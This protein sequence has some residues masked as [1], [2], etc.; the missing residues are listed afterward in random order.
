MVVLLFAYR[1][2][3]THVVGGDITYRH[4][5]NDSFEITLILYI[6]CING[7]P[8]AIAQDANAMIGVF[9]TTGNLLKTLL[10]NRSLPI[11]IN[12]VN[13]NCVQPPSN[14]C[15][16]KYTYTYYTSLPQ[17][18]G[19]IILAFQRCCRN[20]SITNIINPNATGA[21]YWTRI[22]DTAQTNGYNS[23][24][25]FY[26]LPPNFLCNNSAFVFNHA[27]TDP[28]GDSLSYELYTPYMGADQSNPLPR[29]PATPP[30]YGVVWASPFDVNN[31]MKGLPEL[32]ID[33]I[34][35]VITMIPKIVGQF[36]VGIGVKEFRKGLLIGFTRRDF[37]FNVL[38]CQ[39]NI[40]SSFTKD[41]K[42]CNDTVAFINNSV[43]A[44]SYLWDFGDSTSSIDTSTLKEPTYVYPKLGIYFIKLL[45]K[46]GNCSDSATAQ[47]IISRDTIPFAGKDTIICIGASVLLGTNDTNMFNYRWQPA[48]F[49]NDSSIS[50]PLA[51]PQYS[52]KYYVTRTNDICI[53]TDTV[54]IT[55]KN[56]QAHFSG[57]T[58]VNCRE[59]HIVIDSVTTFQEM[60]WYLNDESATLDQIKAKLLEKGKTYLVK[61]LVSD[62]QC[63][64]SLEK[65]LSAFSTDTISFIPNVFTP[66]NDK[67]NDCY[68]IEYIQLEKECANLLI[69][70]RWGALMYNSDEDGTC[71]DGNWKGTQATEGVYFY[72]LKH[73]GK[74]YHGTIT[75]I[76]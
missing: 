14:A 24:P 52:I 15:V 45:V 33:S 62:G 29:P 48:L 25:V 21:T 16:D 40:V 50:R 44:D 69:Y 65:L 68:R 23:S 28:D 64:D 61:L 42:V 37:Q 32:K 70:N 53:N 76:R 56:L 43:G 34:S 3:A 51:T 12:S 63:F 13:Y 55:V 59:A 57:N 11:R 54:S 5:V 19:G 27:A 9:D 4:I 18:P 73:M 36:V 8:Q 75:L 1:V 66:N 35:G 10:V 6:D 46:K 39:F 31:M 30:Y 72:I 67:Q 20:N 22:R 41:L 7:N 60:K 47:V 38:A 17:I 26:T 58:L 49:L 71:W 74:E 2:T